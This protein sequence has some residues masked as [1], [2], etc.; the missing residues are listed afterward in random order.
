MPNAA[1]PNRTGLVL[2]LVLGFRLRFTV[3]VSKDLDRVSG[4]TVLV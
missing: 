3:R 4:V 2:G 1:M